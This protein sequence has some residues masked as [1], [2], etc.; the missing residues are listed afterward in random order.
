[1]NHSNRFLLHRA[2][3][4]N[5]CT[6][7]HKHLCILFFPE[8]IYCSTNKRTESSF[9]ELSRFPSFQLNE[10][11]KRENIPGPQ[12]EKEGGTFVMERTGGPAHRDIL[13]QM[14][15]VVL[16]VV[17]DEIVICYSQQSHF[18]DGEDVHELF[19]LRSL[20]EKTQNIFHCLVQ[21][22]SNAMVLLRMFLNCKGGRLHH[23]NNVSKLGMTN[24]KTS[25]S[26]PF[27]QIREEGEAFMQQQECTSDFS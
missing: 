17:C 27:R 3:D 8:W 22:G 24:A 4:Q 11:S 5:S 15:W 18:W 19:H 13:E 10:N 23:K 26:D 2:T 1:M 6:G 7:K 16:D 20:L 12:P 9:T 25:L 14:N 21:K